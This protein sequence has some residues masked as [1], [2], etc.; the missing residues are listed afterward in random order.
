LI[1]I[2]GFAILNYM[3]HHDLRVLLY[4]NGFS[5]TRSGKTE[6]ARWDE[7]DK[8]WQDVTE[9]YRGN[10]HTNTTHRYKVKLDDGRKYVFDEKL[11]KV[12]ALGNAL[13]KRCAEYM[14]PRAQ[15]AYEAGEAVSFDKFSLSRAGISKGDKTL[16]WQEVESV[17]VRRGT[18][19]IKKKGQDR[20]W[21]FAMVSKVPNPMVFMALAKQH[22]P[23]PVQGQLRS[24]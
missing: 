14:L 8:V 18:L 7:V 1:F 17:E 13:Q 12:A 21:A 16:P 20:D 5:H 2:G 22:G 10:V 24:E 9:T 23:S 6:V 4:E 15:E 3:R 19:H 11:G